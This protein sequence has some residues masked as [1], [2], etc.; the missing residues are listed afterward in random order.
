MAKQVV[1]IAG[2][3]GSGKN[4][5][6]TRIMQGCHNCARLV[7]ATTRSMRPGEVDGVDYHFFTQERF[8]EEMSAGN[9][10]EHRFV[11]A[12]GTYY[13]TYLPDLERRIKDKK[14]VFAQVDI[15]GAKLLKERYGATTIFIMPE[16]VEQ[17]RARL[18]AR[19]PEWSKKEFEA[20]MAITENEM[21]AHAPQYD[22]RVVNA[23]GRLDETAREV[24]E[25]LRKEGYNL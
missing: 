4:T 22:Y 16:S 11:P 10:P 21:R 7:T 6:I 18:R 20:R 19:N 3:S 13:G 8:D 2:P 15:E 25:I 14:V 12:L 17:F 5:V 9:I 24:V 1:V 23:D